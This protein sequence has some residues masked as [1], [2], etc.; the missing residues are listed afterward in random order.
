LPETFG[1]KGAEGRNVLRTGTCR[2]RLA[3]TTPTSHVLAKS[4]PE[5]RGGL[6][7]SVKTDH[8]F[9][10]PLRGVLGYLQPLATKAITERFKFLFDL[11]DEGLARVLGAF[12]FDERFI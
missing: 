9:D 4:R 8:L 7:S 6:H 1:H 10:E 5:V 11:S 2:A 3:A 12:Q